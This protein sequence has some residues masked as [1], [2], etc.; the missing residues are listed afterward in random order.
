MIQTLK[1]L[2]KQKHT[3][4]TGKFSS[5]KSFLYWMWRVDCDPDIS[6]NRL[7][8]EKRV[9]AQAKAMAANNDLLSWR[10]LLSQLIWREWRCHDFFLFY[11]SINVFPVSL[12]F[13]LS[14]VLTMK[15]S[16]LKIR[17]NHS[18]P[19]SGSLICISCLLEGTI[20]LCW[21]MI[22]Y[23]F[24]PS[25]RLPRKLNY[26][27]SHVCH[28][29]RTVY[30]VFREKVHQDSVF[31]FVKRVSNAKKKVVW[32]LV[33][34][35]L[36]KK[37]LGG[38]RKENGTSNANRTYKF[39]GTAVSHHAFRIFAMKGGIFIFTWLVGWRGFAGKWITTKPVD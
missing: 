10:I 35:V 38:A 24:S 26:M 1:I 2:H 16:C 23:C 19:F 8:Y 14:S 29:N 39:T 18:T 6:Q 5:F 30:H 28:R 21:G 7:E 27:R 3:P 31:V 22:R 11:T 12:S 15:H 20:T 4:F 32:R 33:G 25:S 17:S 37:T 34:S 13:Y 9:R 36:S